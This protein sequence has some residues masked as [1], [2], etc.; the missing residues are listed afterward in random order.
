MRK[1]FRRFFRTLLAVFI[2]SLIV[3]LWTYIPVI[4]GYVA[5][6]MCSGIFVSGR[7][8]ADIERDELGSF[9]CF[10]LPKYTI[11]YKDSSV[12]ATFFGMASKTSVYRKG[13]G[14]TLI[15]DI[16]AT[17]LVNSLLF[18]RSCQYQPGFSMLW[19]QGS[20]DG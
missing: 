5:K 20:F 2:F 4:T 13:G 8:V 10:H 14:A 15:N 18:G 12:T 9:P 11:S 6:T 16:T 17:E 3:Y 1:F 19:P 7:P